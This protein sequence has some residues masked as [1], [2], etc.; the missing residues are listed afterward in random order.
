MG[1]SRSLAMT[2]LVVVSLVVGTL[3]IMTLAGCAD[4]EREL[5]VTEL[6]QR[7]KSAH[8]P[9]DY[10]TDE[11]IMQC[12]KNPDTRDMCRK[13]DTNCARYNNLKSFVN[14]TWEARDGK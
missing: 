4:Q 9:C 8:L 13:L 7:P 2:A 14:R 12:I 5:P 11:E 10:A 3:G 1:S 6:P